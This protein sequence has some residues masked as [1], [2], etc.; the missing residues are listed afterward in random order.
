ME[1]SRYSIKPNAGKGLNG[2]IT[3]FNV[4]GKFDPA[5]LD[6]NSDLAD[7]IVKTAL[8]ATQHGWIQTFVVT[9]F[10]TGITGQRPSMVG[11]KLLSTRVG[12]PQAL[13]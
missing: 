9:G 13:S 6:S 11:F 7:G 10:L 12:N 1:M 2:F 3:N 8:S 4:A 5:W